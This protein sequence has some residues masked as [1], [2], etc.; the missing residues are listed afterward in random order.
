MYDYMQDLSGTERCVRTSPSSLCTTRPCE[1]DEAGYFILETCCFSCVASKYKIILILL[2]LLFPF[3]IQI[4]QSS[5][6]KFMGDREILT[7][8]C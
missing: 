4:L 7:L 6:R 2:L 5:L 8:V 3:L 1:A